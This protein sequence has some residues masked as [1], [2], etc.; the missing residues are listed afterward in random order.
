MCVAVG[1]KRRPLVRLRGRAPPPC[2]RRR[3]ARMPHGAR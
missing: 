2:R 3:L 1:G